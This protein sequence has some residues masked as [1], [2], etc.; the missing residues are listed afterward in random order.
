MNNN[1]DL[2][3]SSDSEEHSNNTLNE[4][5]LSTLGI[6]YD[7]VSIRKCRRHFCQILLTHVHNIYHIQTK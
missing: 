1:K 5:K 4:V 7:A 3:D 2:S 6:K